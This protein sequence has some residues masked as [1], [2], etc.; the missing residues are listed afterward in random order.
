[1]G[2]LNDGINNANR[3]TSHQCKGD[4]LPRLIANVLIELFHIQDL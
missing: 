2:T 3:W 4:A 1:M